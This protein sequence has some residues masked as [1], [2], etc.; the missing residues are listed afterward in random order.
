[1]A[2]YT[3]ALPQFQF[4]GEEESQHAR[5]LRYMENLEETKAQ[6]VILEQKLADQ[7]GNK[8]LEDMLVE[9]RH[10]RKIWERNLT[11]YQELRE[12]LL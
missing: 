6:V 4:D 12:S 9:A 8:E 5:E 11:T 1:M 7:P 2:Q 3:T 10:W